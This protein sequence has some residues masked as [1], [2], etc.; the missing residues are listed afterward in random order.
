MSERPFPNHLY[1]LTHR[2]NRLGIDNLGLLLRC[3]VGAPRIWLCEEYLF[4][5]ILQ[6]VV[7]RKHWKE[8]DV[9][10][11]PV[12]VWRMPEDCYAASSG[13]WYTTESIRPCFFDRDKTQNL[14]WLSFGF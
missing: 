7:D 14:R 10:V 2:R 11:I 1:H 13:L 3:A 9:I 4:G 6:H 12:H 8:A 5:K